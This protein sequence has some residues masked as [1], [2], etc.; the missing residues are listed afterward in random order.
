[1]KI[2]TVKLSDELMQVLVPIFAGCNPKYFRGNEDEYLLYFLR[3]IARLC[4]SN[5]PSHIYE[6]YHKTASEE[7]RGE[8]AE[9]VR[10]TA[11]SVS[12]RI[13]HRNMDS[14]QPAIDAD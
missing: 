6:N 2:V 12:N 3:H 5:L 8:L 13:A 10:L 7:F 9:V 4:G 1:M 11:I 14:G